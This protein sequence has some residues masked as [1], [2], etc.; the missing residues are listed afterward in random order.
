MYKGTGSLRFYS[1]SRITHCTLLLYIQNR[2]LF[3]GQDLLTSAY[4]SAI[5]RATNNFVCAISGATLHKLWHHRLAHPRNFVIQTIHKSC[6]G[7]PNFSHRSPF[8]KC[9]SC[10]QANIT[11]MIKGYNSERKYASVRGQRF[12]M[13]FGF[14]CGNFKLKTEDSKL[15]TSKDGYNGY[16]LISDEYYR[17]SWRF[18]INS[19]EPPI[20]IVK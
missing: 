13:D 3:V 12:Q 16:L 7:I 17:Y 4:H 9:S 18:S 14:V 10:S 1:S 2:L 8:F 11:K 15:V 6:D 20:T 5:N 19:K